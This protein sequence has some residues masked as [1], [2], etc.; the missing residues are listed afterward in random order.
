MNLRMISACLL[1]IPLGMV[2]GE[3]RRPAQSTQPVAQQHH[4]TPSRAETGDQVFAANCSRCHAA[5]M[6]LSPRITGTVV[7]HMR[8]RARLSQNDEQLL[9]K[10][11][12]P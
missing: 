4:A 12:A 8:V 7:M 6:A 3:P 10:F 9:L 2:A 5:P 1:M 11:L